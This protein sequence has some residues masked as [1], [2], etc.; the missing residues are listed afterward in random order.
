MIPTRPR[1]AAHRK[2][3]NATRIR[4]EIYDMN[5]LRL[6]REH[7]AGPALRRPPVCAEPD[8]RRRRDSDAR[9]RHRRERRDLSARQR[10]APADPARR[11][12][13]RSS[14]RIGINTHDTGRTGQFLSRRPIFTE[15]LW[16]A[17]RAEQQGFSQ[18]FA[19]GITDLEPRHRRRVP[20]RARHLRERRFLRGARRR[21]AGRPRADGRPTIRRDAARLAP[22]CRTGS[23]SHATA[24]ARR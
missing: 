11:D 15:P 22:C 14:C 20:P 7:L 21:G 2:L 23:G 4:E 6:H 5:T 12:V 16:Q 3:G 19:W 9:A 8:L 17:I 10:R 1:D 13:R 18:L 24:A